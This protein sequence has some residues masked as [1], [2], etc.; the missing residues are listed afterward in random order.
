VRTE[1]EL[2]PA[3]DVGLS[4]DGPVLIDVHVDPAGY[5]RQLKAMRG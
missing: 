2:E 5:G 3:L 4:A 1:A